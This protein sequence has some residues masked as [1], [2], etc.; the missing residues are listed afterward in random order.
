MANAVKATNN[1]NSTS[2]GDDGVSG[3]RRGLEEGPRSLA[4]IRPGTVVQG[5]YLVERV[6]GQGGMGVVIAAMNL[7][8]NKR[9]AL[10]FLEVQGDEMPDDFHARFALE[11]RV[12]AKLRNP[13][14]A[15]VHEMGV[16]QQTFPFMVMDYLE[17]EDLRTLR[18]RGSRIPLGQ[19]IGY[20]IQICEGLA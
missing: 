11:A 8:E 4:N 17:G 19:A 13:H 20:V 12:C 9:V 3:V 6:L 7:E 2:N 5:K 10:K 15:R 18:K 16:W 14:I 1:T